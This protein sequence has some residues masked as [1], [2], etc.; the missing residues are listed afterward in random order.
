[1]LRIDRSIGAAAD[2]DNSEVSA[3]RGTDERN[4][5][6]ENDLYFFHS[7]FERER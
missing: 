5:Q 1:M 7:F 3:D 2:L 4:D 6:R